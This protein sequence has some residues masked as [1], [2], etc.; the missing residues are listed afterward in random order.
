MCYGSGCHHEDPFT[1][2]CR[3]KR[4]EQCPGDETPTVNVDEHNETY[5]EEQ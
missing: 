5:E 4:G 1:G 2:E 3:R